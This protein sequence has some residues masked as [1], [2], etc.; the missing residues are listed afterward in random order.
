MTIARRRGFAV[1]G[2]TTTLL[3]TP[4]LACPVCGSETGQQVRAG[5]AGDG[6]GL[7]L[8]A[9]IVPFVVVAGIVAAVHFGPPW[10][11]K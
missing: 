2:L 7:A 9:T 6:V 8:T 4:A 10:T 1:I 5:L 11:R 3:S